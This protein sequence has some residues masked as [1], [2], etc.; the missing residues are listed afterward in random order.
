MPCVIGGAC[1][2][3]MGAAF[4]SSHLGQRPA[5][6]GVW[7]WG[8]TGAR[9]MRCCHTEGEQ[10]QPPEIVQPLPVVLSPEEYH[11]ALCGAV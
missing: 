1:D 2:E 5:T 11:L 3:N 8:A 7:P 6:N 9:L 4:V 10:P